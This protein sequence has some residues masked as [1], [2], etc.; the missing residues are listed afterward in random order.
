[1]NEKKLVLVVDNKVIEVATSIN[2][3]IT[4]LYQVE[5]PENYLK[6]NPFVVDITS[7]DEDVRPGWIY[8][9]IT[10]ELSEPTV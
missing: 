7:L 9:P 2:G 10:K 1:M 8:N 6:K 3:V 5:K 4:M